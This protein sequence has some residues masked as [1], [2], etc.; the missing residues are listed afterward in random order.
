MVKIMFSCLI[1]QPQFLARLGYFFARYLIRLSVS[2]LHPMR[3]KRKKE[4][5]QLRESV[6]GGNK[7]SRNA[8]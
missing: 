2:L 1:R 7:E 6:G 4:E 3:N 8:D 5:E